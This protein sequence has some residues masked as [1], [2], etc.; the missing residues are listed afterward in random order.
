[1]LEALELF[2]NDPEYRAE[3]EEI[4]RLKKAGEWEDREDAA[5]Y[6][7]KSKTPRQRMIR[8]QLAHARLYGSTD[9]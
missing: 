9:K 1:M 5:A 6:V 7:N 3:M 2:T 4:V 8:K